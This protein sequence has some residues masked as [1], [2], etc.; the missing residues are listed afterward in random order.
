MMMKQQQQ[1]YGPWSPS[2]E[3]TIRSPSEVIC[4]QYPVDNS[5][6]VDRESVQGTNLA[7][8]LKEV[9]AELRKSRHMLIQAEK[10]R[11]I[12]SLVGAITHEFNNP[13]CGIRSV[14]A[15]LFRKTDLAT[16]DHDLLRLA[17]EQC[18]RME[19]LSRELQRFNIPFSDVR[20][21]FDLH[22]VIDSVLLLLNKHLKVRKAAVR[23]EYVDDPL[24]LVGAENQIKQVV[25]NLIKNSAEALA[26]NGGD[27]C[28]RTA[29][30]EA[31]VHITVADTGIG[32]SAEYLPHLFEPRFADTNGSQKTC[33]G[34]AVAHGIVREHRG[35]IRVT[36]HP[37]QG[38][39][40]SVLLPAGEHGSEGEQSHGADIHPGG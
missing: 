19:R 11:S 14:L 39:T 16:G 5:I 32:I 26:K 29:R 2:E 18:D 10:M 33:L 15:R 6:G 40:F 12:G 25:F 38:T 9:R 8:E 28:I 21:A 22:R 35:E 17:L 30:E 3:T 27:I 36:S 34:L 24:L 31:F 37:G 4:E 23:K 13:L 7:D 1:D 20:E